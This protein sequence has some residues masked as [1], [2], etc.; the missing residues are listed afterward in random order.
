MN[1][2]MSAS[3]M[4]EEINREKIHTWFDLGLYIDRLKENN[5]IPTNEFHGSYDDFKGYLNKRAMAFVTFHYSVDGVTIEV[6]KYAKIF[7]RHLP[8]VD[9]HYIAGEFFQESKELIQPEVKKLELKELRGFDDWDLYED[10]YFTRLER[11]SAEYNAL[12]LKFWKHAK[13]WEGILKKT[14]FP[15]FI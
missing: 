1:R 2:K 3:R 11:G 10:F 14:I 15:F 9:I 13:N 8:D 6:E 4:M 12:I 7:R 5:P